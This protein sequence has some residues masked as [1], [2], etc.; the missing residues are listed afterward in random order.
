MPARLRS[1]GVLA[2]LAITGACSSGHA[3]LVSHLNSQSPG[4]VSI[5]DIN[6]V[7][8]TVGPV[9]VGEVRNRS[10]VPIGGVQVIA[11]L[12]DAKGSAIGKPQSSFTFLQVLPPGAKASFAIPFVESHGTA[13]TV[14]ATVQANAQLEVNVVPLSVVSQ[15]AMHLGSAYLVTGTVKNTSLEPVDFTNVVATF[16]GATGQVV[17]AANSIGTSDTVVPGASTTFHIT[18]LEQG[19]LVRRYVLASEGK[20]VPAS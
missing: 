5:T 3:G 15:Q 4:R 11:A 1:V 2:V 19:P 9:V 13:A 8:S 6:V 18:L 16:Y 12:K 20:V 17:G 14:S 7:P 10:S